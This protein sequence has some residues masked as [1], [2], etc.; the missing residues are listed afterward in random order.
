M[1]SP[2]TPPQNA[3]LDTRTRIETPEGIDL[4]L[5]P[6]GLVPRALAFGID[7]GIRALA[8]GA[9]LLVFSLLDTLGIGL[10]ALSLF[11]LNWWYMVV[12]EVMNQGR[13]P[14][15]RFMGLRV[16]HDDGTP[17]GWAS[18]LT[19]NLLRFV[20]ML[21]FGYSVGA[22]S[23][24]NHPQFKRAGDMAAGT[25]VV[26]DDLPIKRPVLP[27]AIPVL[28]PVSLRLEEQRAVLSLAERQSELSEGRA[29]ELAVI[30]AEPLRIPTDQALAQVNGMA[31]SLL[32]PA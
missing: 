25:L 16:I 28:A 29:L 4:V 13:T 10:A 8:S 24:L 9:L 3:A 1:S 22:V 26:H 7:F 21:P 15:K 6:A 30:I 19:R 23:C 17:I 12:F 5:R 18:S 31:R 27:Q 32:G 2:P 14:G 20:D 11:I